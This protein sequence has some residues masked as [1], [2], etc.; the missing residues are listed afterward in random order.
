MPDRSPGGKGDGVH[1]GPLELQTG[2]LSQNE[3]ESGEK[4]VENDK[5]E[6]G[7]EVDVRDSERKCGDI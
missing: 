6:G 1:S 4:T 3:Q 2:S 5:E 7:I